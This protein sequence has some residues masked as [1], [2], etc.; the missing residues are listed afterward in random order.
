MTPSINIRVTRKEK[1]EL[2]ALSKSLHMSLSGFLR[3]AA[4]VEAERVLRGAP[5]CCSAASPCNHQKKDPTTICDVCQQAAALTTANRREGEACR[6]LRKLLEAAVPFAA[7]DW[8]DAELEDDNCKLTQHSGAVMVRDW[9]ALRLA[10]K[11]ASAALTA[12][13]QTTANH[14]EGET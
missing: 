9:R 12:R 14:R 5:G 4:T 6:A 13:E 2:K 3:H 10:I 8:M 1:A 11:E 7:H